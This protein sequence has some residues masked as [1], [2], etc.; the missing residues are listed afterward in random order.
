LA[1]NRDEKAR[2]ERQQIADSKSKAGREW[3]M[4]RKED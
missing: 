1:R 3:V 2:T 4:Q